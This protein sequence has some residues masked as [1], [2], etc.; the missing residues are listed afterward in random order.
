[1]TP[2]CFSIEIHEQTFTERWC[3]ATYEV[4]DGALHVSG[5]MED[6]QREALYAAGHWLIVRFWDDCC[7]E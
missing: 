5:E 7:A 3:R 4:I 1:M 6:V 2:R